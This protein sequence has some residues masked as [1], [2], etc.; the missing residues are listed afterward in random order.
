[1]LISVIFCTIVL[2]IIFE[3]ILFGSLFSPLHIDN[4]YTSGIQ[5]VPRKPKTIGITNC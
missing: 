3:V 1:M 5:R 4:A 2:G